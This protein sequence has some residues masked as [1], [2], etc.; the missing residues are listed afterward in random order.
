MLPIEAFAPI[1]AIRPSL[2]FWAECRQ[3]A[4]ALTTSP[5]MREA[6]IIDGYDVWPVVRPELA[7]VALLQFPW[8]ARAMDEAAAALDH[9]KPKVVVTYAEAGGWGRA[10]VLEARRRGIPTVGIQHGFIYRHWL[11]YLHEP[12]EMAPL[13]ATSSDRGFPAPDRTLVFDELAADHLR[14]AGRFPATGVVVTGSPRLDVLAGEIARVDLDAVR[15]TLGIASGEQVVLVAA[16]FT[17]LGHWFRPLVAAATSLP[18]VRVLVKCHPAETAEPYERAAA[19]LARVTVVPPTASL[20]TLLAVA[21]LVATVNSTVAVDAL[22]L[23]IPSLVVA[24]PNNLSPFVEAGVMTGVAQPEALPGA[25]DALLYDEA[26]RSGLAARR[27]EF[28]AR[29][30]LGSDG[31]A[32]A[33][34]ASV[35]A[36]L[37]QGRLHSCES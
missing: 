2:A 24:L 37:A 4:R 32:A 28:L 29:H 12:D 34:A 20:A 8:S 3:A 1:S 30:R 18:G 21:R 6:A 9:L 36:E 35:I 23:E 25:I 27:Q 22:V 10:I 31:G 15:H 13:D 5:G 14:R 7:G 11:N 19:G 16:K 33:R 26:Y 17:Q